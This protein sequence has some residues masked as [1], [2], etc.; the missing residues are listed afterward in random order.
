MPTLFHA[1]VW[2]IQVGVKH[3]RLIGCDMTG[4]DSPLMATWST[5]TNEDFR[6]RWA[7]ERIMLAH[8]I[9]QYRARGA[10]LERWR[11]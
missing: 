9:R 4:T 11:P 7:L 1:L 8:T 2:L 3:V 5:E 6:Y 10:R